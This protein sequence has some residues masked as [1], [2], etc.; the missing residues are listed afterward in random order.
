MIAPDMKT[1]SSRVMSAVALVAGVLFM[2]A[3]LRAVVWAPT[4]GYSAVQVIILMGVWAAFCAAACRMYLRSSA[5]PGRMAARAV[6]LGLVLSSGIALRGE[7]LP[8]Q[9]LGSAVGGGIVSTV[10]WAILTIPVALG[11]IRIRD[12]ADRQLETPGGNVSGLLVGSWLLLALPM[13]VTALILVASG[14]HG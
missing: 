10:F 5:P 2:A 11:A 3:L 12:R 14:G 13:I 9:D 7:V 8:S 4:A 1:L 6:A